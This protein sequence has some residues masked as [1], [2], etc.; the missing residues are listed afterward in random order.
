[1]VEVNGRPRFVTGGI[2][3][4]AESHSRTYD[5][6]RHSQPAADPRAR[7]RPRAR[8]RPRR[9]PR[10]L[11]NASYVGQDGARRRRPGGTRGA[12]RRPL[13]VDD[14]RI[15]APVMDGQ[16]RIDAWTSPGGRAGARE[17]WEREML[18]RLEELDE[19]DRRYG[20]GV[21]GP[22][23]PP[24]LTGSHRRHRGMPR[25]E[26]HRRR[27]VSPV[28]PGLLVVLCLLLF[29]FFKSPTTTGERLRPV[30]RRAGR[31]RRV[32]RVR[33]QGDQRAPGRLG[34][35]RADP[36][37]RQP[38]RRARSLGGDRRRRGVRGRGGERVRLRVGRHQRRPLGATGA[39]ATPATGCRSS[40]TGPTPD[41][42]PSLQGDTV[43]IGG[44][45]RRDR[46]GETRLRHR[47]GGPRRGGVRADGAGRRRTAAATLILAHELGHVLGLD[48]VDDP[49]QL[50]NPSYV[51]QR[52][53]GDGDLAGLKI[54]RDMPCG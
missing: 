50:M 36:L 21:S 11:M 32:L 33:R 12:A 14:Q 39:R 6:L 34:R 8:A 5:P 53:F 23:Q 10:Q 27:T 22:S 7:D 1:M 15:R 51:G 30:R 9:R 52:G 42:V 35:L 49:E 26:R 40:S 24:G 29:V 46:N 37:R 54:L 13:R 28:L 19:L 16:A 18:R 17:R 20:L 44:S 38:R 2:A 4:D 48:H 25:V 3:L 43:G 31:Q 47:G 45:Q 41:E